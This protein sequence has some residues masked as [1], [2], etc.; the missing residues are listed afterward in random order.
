M[1]FDEL[2]AKYAHLEGVDIAKTKINKTD[3]DTSAA[4]KAE[5]A[6][7]KQAETNLGLELQAS[8][9]VALDQLGGIEFLKQLGRDD[10]AKFFQLLISLSGKPT[11]NK[12]KI[13]EKDV[14]GDFTTSMLTQLSGGTKNDE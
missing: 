1:K 11:T 8:F 3:V 2:K 13:A 14:L 6:R 4:I 10:P 12:D 5:V 7:L 9:K